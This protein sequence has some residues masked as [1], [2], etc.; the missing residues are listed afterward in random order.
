V[1]H[2]LLPLGEVHV[3]PLPGQPGELMSHHKP[4]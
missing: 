1:L 2:G 3:P 4:D